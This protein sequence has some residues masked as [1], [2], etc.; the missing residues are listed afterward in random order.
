MIVRCRLCEPAVQAA[1]LLLRQSLSSKLSVT[2]LSKGHWQ[3]ADT[4]VAGIVHCKAEAVC[5]YD[6]QHEL[7]MTLSAQAMTRPSAHPQ[8]ALLA[9]HL[10]PKAQSKQ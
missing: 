9:K 8:A 10:L 7:C 4:A 1:M 2:Y 3:K 5:M 6:A